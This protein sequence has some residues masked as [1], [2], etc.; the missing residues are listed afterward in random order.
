VAPARA[1]RHRTRAFKGKKNETPS[2][3]SS[4][5]RYREIGAPELAQHAFN[6]VFRPCDLDLSALHFEYRLR[7]VGHADLATLAPLEVDFY[8][9]LFFFRSLAFSHPDH[10][11]SGLFHATKAIHALS[12]KA[13]SKLVTIY[14]SP[15]IVASLFNAYGKFYSG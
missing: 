8:D 13:R 7:A 3:E 6:A 5:N 1:S 2:R 10:I 4:F 9:R 14:T 11:R 12:E 15:K